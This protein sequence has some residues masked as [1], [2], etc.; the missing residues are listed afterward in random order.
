MRNNQPV[1]Q[2][3]YAF[4][5]QQRLI[6]T[7]DLKGQITYCNDIFAEVS[8]F[9]RDELIRAP[10]NLVRHPDVPPAVFEH[11]W[12]TLK[13]GKPWMG[14]VKNRR[15]TG[16]HYWV[17]AYVT[18]I[19]DQ[20]R[21]VTGYESVRTKPSREQVQRAEALY[22]RLNAGKSGVP[23]RNSWLPVLKKWLPF[24]LVSQV[25]FLVGAS[26][27][28]AIGFVAAA[29]LSVP[30]GLAGL[31]WQQRGLRRLMQLAQ[32][33]TSDPLIACMYTDSRGV[34]AQLEMAMLSQQAHLKTCLTRLQDTAVQLQGQ[35]KQADTLAQNCANGLAQQHQ[36]TEQVATAIN[37]MAATTQEVAS[38]VALA[39][40]ATREASR[41][42]VHG[43]EVT[44]DTRKAIQQLSES[45]SKAGESV[46][47]LASDSEAIGSVV[48]VI[49]SIADQTN[50]LAL[51]AAIEAAR[52]GDSG[53][54]FAVV[55]DEVR[56]LAQRTAAATGEIHQ[57][58]EK[59]QSQAQHAVSTTEQ[60]RVHAARGV[61]QMIQADQALSGINE[62]MGNIIDMTTQ[63]ASATE[64]QSAVAEE[65]SQ[66]VSTIARLAD[67][68]SGAARSSALLSEALAATAEGQYS[69]V[70][71]FNR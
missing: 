24:I 44:A 10:H 21:Q 55:A 71:R 3:E 4:P 11:M 27:D 41:L 1:T 13:Q 38:N 15:K 39:A 48:D 5:D 66:N 19:L 33:T 53:R 25:G 2:R 60:G 32:E 22:A 35:A 8:G 37:E 52:A 59:L 67:Q 54:G 7:T 63:I 23:R 42:T 46:N 57:L 47:Q 20:Q 58:I 30:L 14:I 64:E 34:E 16:D 49:K 56:Q 12:V 70:E 26:F 31:H 9:S 45:V 29:L 65:I 28:H 51:N 50:L 62:A 68:T 18:P 43:R 69:L 17:N 6:S 40:D 36:E 61:E